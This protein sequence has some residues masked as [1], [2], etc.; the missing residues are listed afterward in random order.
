MVKNLQFCN[1]YHYFMRVELLGIPEFFK[2][3]LKNDK[4]S[5][6]Y[7]ANNM[8]L[9]S[10]LLMIFCNLINFLC[11]AGENVLRI[12]HEWKMSTIFPARFFLYPRAKD[13]DG[14]N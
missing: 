12:S 5:D 6:L 7:R 11:C 14:I 8:I 2:Q 13:L 10:R 3:L 1:R 4:A 9:S